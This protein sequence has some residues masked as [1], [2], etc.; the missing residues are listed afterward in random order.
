MLPRFNQR[1]EIRILKKSGP[2]SVER[3][4]IDGYQRKA[5]RILYWRV[6]SR[7]GTHPVTYQCERGLL[8]AAKSN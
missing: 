5:P 8:P 2:L 3:M 6:I 1:A 4:P 7:S